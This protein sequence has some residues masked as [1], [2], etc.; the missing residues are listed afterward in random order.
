MFILLQGAA[1]AVKGQHPC[2]A[3]EDSIAVEDQHYCEGPGASTDSQGPST[4]L[5]VQ[6][7]AL[8]VRGQHP[9]V[10]PGGS[11][12]SQGPAPHW[13]SRGQH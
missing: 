6:G 3:L 11:T 13:R 4:P 9:T 1:L 7:T 12:D 8:T 2:G 10:G 5:E